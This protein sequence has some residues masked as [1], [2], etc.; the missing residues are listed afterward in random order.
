MNSPT[1]QLSKH[2]SSL[3]A[4]LVGCSPSSIRNSK[5]FAAFANSLLLGDDETLV[6]F[7]VVSLFMSVPTDL[8][9]NIARKCLIEDECLRDRMCLEVEDIVILLELCLDATFMGFR[10]CFYQQCF[11]T[12]MGSPVSVTVANLVM[13]EIEERALSTLPRPRF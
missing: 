1:Y 13:E 8:A 6:S 2:L 7:D 9:I 10:G 5:D 12:A 11:G 4:P 3:L